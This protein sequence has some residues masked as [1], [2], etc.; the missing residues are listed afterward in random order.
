MLLER[1]AVGCI[2]RAL[3]RQNTGCG[4]ARNPPSADELSNH[5]V[6]IAAGNRPFRFDIDH[7]RAAAAAPG[8]VESKPRHQCTHDD[9][10]ARTA[11]A[12]AHTPSICSNTITHTPLTSAGSD[13]TEGSSCELKW[14]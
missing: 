10:D 8:E 2:D 5:D 14:R 4:T 3:G 12:A 6:E 13:R 1:S 11:Q 7:R 9:A